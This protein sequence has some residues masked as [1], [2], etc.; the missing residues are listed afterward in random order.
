MKDSKNDEQFHDL[1]FLFGNWSEEEFQEFRESRR[2]F[3]KIDEEL[4]QEVE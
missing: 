4:W 3:E 1:D 2:D